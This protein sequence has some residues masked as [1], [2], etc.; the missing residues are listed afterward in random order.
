MQG[1]VTLI[2]ELLEWSFGVA[3]G[4][5]QGWLDERFVPPPAAGSRMD[6]AGGVE[7]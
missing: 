7:G 5:P 1:E 4:Q 6:H 3:E 2:P